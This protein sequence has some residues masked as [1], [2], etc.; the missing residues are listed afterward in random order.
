MRPSRAYA[1]MNSKDSTPLL[2][3][4]IALSSIQY[5]D[6]AIASYKQFCELRGLQ[7][8]GMRFQVLLAQANNFF[9]WIPYGQEEKKEQAS[10]DPAHVRTSNT[11]VSRYATEKED[12]AQD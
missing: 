11:V 4:E 1:T 10:A 7:E 2:N 8:R 6:L 9:K 5:D 3:G 12:A